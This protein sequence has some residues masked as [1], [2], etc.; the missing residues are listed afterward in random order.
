MLRDPVAGAR[1][2]VALLAAL[3][4]AVGLLGACS[5]SDRAQPGHSA[6]P[7]AGDGRGAMAGMPASQ[8]TGDDDPATT[9]TTM[10]V[11][12]QRAIAEA[13]FPPAP[14]PDAARHVSTECR[15]DLVDMDVEGMDHGAAAMADAPFTARRAPD[16]SYERDY[17]GANARV[18]TSK[19]PFDATPT[20]TQ[21][22][23]AADFV[24]TVRAAVAR[25]GWD[26]PAQ[27]I[28][29]GFQPLQDC[30]S[31]FINIAYA[32]DGRLLDPNRPEYLVMAARPD[33]TVHVEAVMFMAQ[34][35]AHGPQ[36]FGSLAT[37]H[38]HLQNACMAGTLMVPAVGTG[39]PAGTQ[40]LHRT[41]EML[42][43]TLAGSPFRLPM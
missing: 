17:T 31:H 19:V 25:H 33:G 24:A 4:L 3:L 29:D 32:L 40:L 36:E 6:H 39:C 28:R 20:P 8:G 38:Y 11:A 13:A 43:V 9:T 37:W 23:D 22:R 21:A 2:L 30:N 41:P 12:R 14:S 26:D 34:G 16:G 7:S 1:R 15:N 27:A 10:A 18:E 42:H 5:S 35:M